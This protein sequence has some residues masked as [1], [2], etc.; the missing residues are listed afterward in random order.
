MTDFLLLVIDRMIVGVGAR[1]RC[2]ARPVV[3]AAASGE[4]WEQLGHRHTLHA[5][6]QPEAALFRVQTAAP[7]APAAPAALTEAAPAA[8]QAVGKLRLFPCSCRRRRRRKQRSS[9]RKFRIR[10][11]SKVDYICFI[12]GLLEDSEG[13]ILK[14][15]LLRILGF[16]PLDLL[17][18]WILWRF[19]EDSLRILDW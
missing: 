13:R 5:D 3:A 18:L 19:F 8:A 16:D 7:A 15:G 14:L 10:F 1:S 12:S 9:K 4:Q 6:D 11:Q 17:W 2:P